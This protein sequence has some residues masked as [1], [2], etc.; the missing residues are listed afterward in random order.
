MTTIHHDVYAACRPE[1]VW[2]LLADLEAVQHYNGGVRRAAIDGV[3]RVGVGARRSC[4]LIPKGRVVERVTHWE[5]GR[6][7]GLEVVESDWP[8][9][10]MRWVT[11]VDAQGSGT[12]ITQ[13][14]E[15]EVKF[16]WFGAVLDRLM[17][18]RKLTS[19]LDGVFASLARH[20]EGALQSNGV[21][22]EA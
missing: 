14:L 21:R 22:R 8:I 6:A 2:A 17:M 12:R 19:T 13:T 1:N 16:G 10:F 7:L 4:E 20:A 15:Y 18:K 3:Q 5:D 9:H 11:R